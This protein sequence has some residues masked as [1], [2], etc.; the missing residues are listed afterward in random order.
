MTKRKSKAK[1]K[2]FSRPRL[3]AGTFACV[4]KVTVDEAAKKLHPD[5]VRPGTAVGR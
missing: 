3:R 5:Y 1:R 2:A 4:R